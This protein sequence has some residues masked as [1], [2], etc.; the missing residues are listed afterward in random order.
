LVKGAVRSSEIET[1]VLVQ[2]G[3]NV[4]SSVMATFL[5]RLL[6]VEA[7]AVFGLASPIWQES[8]GVEPERLM[9]VTKEA[10]HE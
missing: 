6:S 2:V 1:G 10:V 3:R 4:M 8:A 7:G 9:V 5:D